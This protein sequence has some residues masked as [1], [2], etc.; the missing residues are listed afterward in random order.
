MERSMKFKYT[1]LYVEDVAASMAFYEA[2]FGLQKGF[3]HEA[4]DYGE[5]LTGET[6]LAF[7]A[8]ALMRQIGKDVGDAD[9]ARPVFE[10]ALETDDVPA[11]FARA[12]KAG[13]TPL[14]A[15]E[16]MP[17]GQVISY[18]SDADGILVEICAPIG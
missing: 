2:A 5:M 13:A 8:K 1:I 9:A 12:V 18:V 7:S 15:P 11:G 6:K 10:I 3:L 16:E 17:W 4:G 14:K